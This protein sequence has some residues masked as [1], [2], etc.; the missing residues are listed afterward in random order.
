MLRIFCGLYYIAQRFDYIWNFKRIKYM[1]FLINIYIAYCTVLWA[2]YRNLRA[3][4]FFNLKVLLYNSVSKIWLLFFRTWNWRSFY[5][6]SI[7]IYNNNSIIYPLSFYHFQIPNA[8]EQSLLLHTTYCI[9]TNPNYIR[10]VG[11][12]PWND[13]NCASLVCV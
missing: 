13:I 9:A 6:I 12:G 5:N 4:R 1:W 11:Y 8:L 3:S 7:N 2:N 10:S